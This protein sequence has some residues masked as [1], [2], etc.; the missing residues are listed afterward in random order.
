M[1]STAVLT[2]ILGLALLALIA[3]AGVAGAQTSVCN[4]KTATW[5]AASGPVEGYEVEVSRNSAAFAKLGDVTGT[6]ATIPGAVGELVK[7]RVRAFA[8]DATPRRTGA[9]SPESVAVTYCPPLGAPGAPTW[10][11]G[12]S[13]AILTEPTSDLAGEPLGPTNP[14][15]ACA[16]WTPGQPGTWLRPTSAGGGGRHEIPWPPATV[17]LP[18]EY[19]ARCISPAGWSDEARAVA[20]V[21]MR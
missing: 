2:T 8:N 3:I 11:A 5:T 12:P 17:D 18:R 6:T 19:V 1:H 9:W 15:W 10:S 7:V 4:S 14:L 21:A 16:A 20:E 13:S